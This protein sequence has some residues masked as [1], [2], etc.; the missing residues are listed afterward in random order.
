MILKVYEFPDPIL[1]KK[2][3]NVENFEKLAPLIQ[4][5][6]DTMHASGGVGLAA[7]QVGELKNIFIAETS[8]G[9]KTFINPQI[10]QQEGVQT[11]T[12]YCLSVPEKG[13]LVRRPER[14][15]FSARDEV[16]EP[17]IVEETGFYATILCHE[18][19]HCNGKLI[20]D[21]LNREE[22]RKLE[23]W[24]SKPRKISSS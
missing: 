22:R 16:G 2:T 7:I 6:Y 11:S 12:E 23:K 18:F 4:D 17:F 1:R 5:M 21:Y 10:I 19:D 24:V 15:V 13:V 14:V 3:S 9:V 8:D 20:V